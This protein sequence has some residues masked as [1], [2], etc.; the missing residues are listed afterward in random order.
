MGAKRLRASL[1]GGLPQKARG[2]EGPAALPAG[3]RR[4][5][6][7]QKRRNALSVIVALEAPGERGGM[8]SH[9][10]GKVT[11]EAFVDELLDEPQRHR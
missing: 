10:R 8:G 4:R 3:E 6:P 5:S 2:E 1:G 7:L 9:V 11:T